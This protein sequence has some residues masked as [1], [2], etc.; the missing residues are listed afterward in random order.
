[1]TST[2][3]KKMSKNNPFEEMDREHEQ[4]VKYLESVSD[5]PT[6]EEWVECMNI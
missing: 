5:P 4:D 6:D 3:A 2:G 1:M